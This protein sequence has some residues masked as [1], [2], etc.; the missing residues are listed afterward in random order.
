VLTKLVTVLATA[1]G[2]LSAGAMLLIRIVLVPFWRTSQPGDFRAWFAAHSDR[3]RRLMVP[4]GTAA[5]ATAGAS[6]AAEALS[7]G[8][9]RGSSAVAAVSAAGVGAIT[10]TVNEPA[11]HDFARQDLDDGETVRL[12]SRW[13][14]WHDVRVVLGIVGTLAAARTLANQA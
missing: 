10:A 7:G 3:I 4:L 13:A 8:N 1:T 9:A 5:A 2:G 12:L 11:N 6:A 14:R